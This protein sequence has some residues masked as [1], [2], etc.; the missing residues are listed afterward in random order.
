MNTKKGH[1]IK[2]DTLSNYGTL[3]AAKITKTQDLYF[4]IPQMVRIYFTVIKYDVS[5]LD[6]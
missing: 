5:N 3:A 6:T 2:E 4:I 1:P